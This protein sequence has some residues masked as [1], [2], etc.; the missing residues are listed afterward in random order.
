MY[1]FEYHVGI[2][3]VTHLYNYTT[4]KRLVRKFNKLTKIRSKFSY[5]ILCKNPQKVKLNSTH[6]RS[7]FRYYI[8]QIK[9]KLN[10]FKETFRPHHK[11]TY[12]FPNGC[13]T[14]LAT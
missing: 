13:G 1:V 2:G 12:N 9:V 3:I 4:L 11:A 5:Y 14:P 6:N 7:K 10:F 8:S